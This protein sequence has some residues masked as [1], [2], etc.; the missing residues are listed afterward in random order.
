MDV[1]LAI[2]S[3][4]TILTGLL[5]LMTYGGGAH[6]RYFLTERCSA[7]DICRAWLRCLLMFSSTI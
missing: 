5:I 2:L 4:L 3:I 1:E 7:G 6:P